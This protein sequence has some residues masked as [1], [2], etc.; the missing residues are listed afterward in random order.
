MDRDLIRKIVFYVIL[1]F[2]I[3]TIIFL[4]IYIF[5]AQ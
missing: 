5:L 1:G 2:I 4:Y 3:V